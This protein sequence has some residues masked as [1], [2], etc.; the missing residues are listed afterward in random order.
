MPP[1]P[2][3]RP[4][5][6][7][8]IA[9]ADAL[10]AYVERRLPAA[11]RSTVDPGD[12][13]QDVIVEALRCEADFRPDGESG[14]RRWL[15]TVARHRMTRLAKRQRT[16]RQGD[17]ESDPVVLLLHEFAVYTRT[18][19]QSAVSHETWA[20]VAVALGRLSKSH[21]DVI[22]LRYIDRLPATEVASR[23]NRTPAAVDQLLKRAMDAL[24]RDLSSL[25]LAHV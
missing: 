19:S 4:L 1:D 9:H 6:A 14:G 10:A 18:G 2:T 21:A 23:T 17:A 12:V 24:R 16:S 20:A 5:L 7:A 3:S 8:L 11:L 13:V 25:I 22:Q 15:F